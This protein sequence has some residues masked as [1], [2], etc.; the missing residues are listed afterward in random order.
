MSQ[1]VVP[2]RVYFAIFAALIVMTLITIQ[3]A[4]LDLGPLNL[5]VALGIATFK[6]TLVILY[7]MHVRYNPR[8]IW[9]V[10]GGSFAWLGVL[11]VITMSDYLSRGWLPFPGK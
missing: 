10:I 7:F 5:T 3:A 2:K 4:Y 8:L 6:A 1:H 9:L 11:V